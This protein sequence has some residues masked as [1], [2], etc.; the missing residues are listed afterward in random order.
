MRKDCLG[1]EVGTFLAASG[2]LQ[3]ITPLVI[4]SQDLGTQ[5]SSES[6]NSDSVEI[7]GVLFE[8][9]SPSSK[10]TSLR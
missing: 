8:C 4:S 7:N 6:D 5:P 2:P 3:P 10:N 1:E 9:I